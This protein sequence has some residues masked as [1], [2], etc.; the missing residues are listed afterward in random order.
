MS[1]YLTI[2]IVGHLLVPLILFAEAIWQ[3][4]VAT[5]AAVWLPAGAILTLALL[6]SVKGAILGLQWALYMHG[7][8]TAATSAGD[9]LMARTERR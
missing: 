2:F 6:P 3:L 7:F 5:H 1:V 9:H 4:E 8:A